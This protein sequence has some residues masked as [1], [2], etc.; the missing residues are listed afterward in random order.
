V[1]LNWPFAYPMIPHD[2]AQYLAGS[3]SGVRRAEVVSERGPESDKRA[4]G[5]IMREGVRNGQ[6]KTVLLIT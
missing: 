5:V 6:T 4:V 3:G 2:R 1:A